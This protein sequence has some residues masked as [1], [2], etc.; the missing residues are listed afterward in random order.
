MNQ[1]SVNWEKPIPPFHK[2][3]TQNSKTHVLND[4]GNTTLCGKQIPSVSGGYRV[5]I[6]DS[7]FADC[8]VCIRLNH[9]AA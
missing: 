7:N 9:N 5:S 8:K 4:D 6:L 1:E 2:C 3:R